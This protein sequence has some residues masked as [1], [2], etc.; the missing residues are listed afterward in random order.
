MWILTLKCGFNNL[1][2]EILIHRE[3]QI[4][5]LGHHMY[6]ITDSMAPALTDVTM[7]SQTNLLKKEGIFW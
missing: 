3:I 6:H 1:D 5:T 7:F 4:C 2:F